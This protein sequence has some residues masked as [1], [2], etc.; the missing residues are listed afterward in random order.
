MTRNNEIPLEPACLSI[1]NYMT[2]QYIEVRYSQKVCTQ[3][4]DFSVIGN[5]YVGRLSSEKARHKTINIILGHL[6]MC[7]C[8]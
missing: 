5:K 2:H 6:K 7:M 1:C 4:K 3:I 8:I